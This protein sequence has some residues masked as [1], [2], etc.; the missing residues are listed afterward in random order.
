MEKK[1]TKKTENGRVVKSLDGIVSIRAKGL[2]FQDPTDRLLIFYNYK[3]MLG[4]GQ[5]IFFWKR[6]FINA[7]IRTWVTS[8]TYI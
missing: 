3:N 1:K 6:S 5:I 4:F 8:V 7:T 2:L